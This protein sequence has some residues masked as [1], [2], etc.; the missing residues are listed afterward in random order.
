[1]TEADDRGRGTEGTALCA[2]PIDSSTRPVVSLGMTPSSFYPNL[3]S[4]PKEQDATP[5]RHVI[6]TKGAE[7]RFKLSSRP[8]PQAEWRDLWASRFGW[9]QVLANIVTSRRRQGQR[10]EAG[11]SHSM[12]R[13]RSVS[14]ISGNLQRQETATR[15]SVRH[16]TGSARGATIDIV[17]L[18]LSADQKE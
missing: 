9:A 1:M 18:N 14:A 11:I 10:Q 3:S 2:A 12:Q 6:P 5:H 17:C 16:Q 8:E 13:Q 4:R 15:T 7:R